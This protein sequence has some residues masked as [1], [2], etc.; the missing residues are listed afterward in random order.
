[1]KKLT[2]SSM[3]KNN[4]E[5]AELMTLELSPSQSIKRIKALKVGQVCKFISWI[6]VGFTAYVHF[7][8]ISKIPAL[9]YRILFGSGDIQLK[10]ITFNDIHATII[11]F[12]QH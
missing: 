2:I 10:N 11:R 12:T 3:Q 8:L 7:R 5:T 4:S 1:M 9:Q 6:F